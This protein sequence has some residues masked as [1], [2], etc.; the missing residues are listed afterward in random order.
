MHRHMPSCGDSPFLA[1]RL[2]NGAS[3]KQAT[4]FVLLILW[5][6]WVQQAAKQACLCTPVWLL[7][8]LALPLGM[9]M[10]AGSRCGLL[11]LKSMA[12]RQVQGGGEEK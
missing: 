3:A 10:G 4:D 9:Q 1:V 8:G 12:D 5:S 6:A 2:A 11:L 7:A